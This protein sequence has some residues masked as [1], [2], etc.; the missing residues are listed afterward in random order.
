MTSK[1]RSFKQ[2]TTRSGASKYTSFLQLPNF[3]RHKQKRRRQQ[4]SV[5]VSIS[6][7]ISESQSQSQ[8][9]STNSSV[10]A[11]YDDGN[12]SISSSEYSIIPIPEEGEE[13][14]QEEDDDNS[15]ICSEADLTV[16]ID[17]DDAHDEWTAN[18]KRLANGNYVYLCGKITSS[19]NKCKRGCHDMIGLYSGCKIHY[20]WEETDHHNS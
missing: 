18:K 4:E 11:A 6:R 3:K 17:F 13:V 5:C 2:L 15:T 14:Q 8:S 20:M 7:T 19:G 9:Q 16:M 10:I 12:I 1:L